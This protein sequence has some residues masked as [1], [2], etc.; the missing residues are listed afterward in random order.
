MILKLSPGTAGALLTLIAAT[1]SA[2]ADWS[3]VM[4]SHYDRKT[5]EPVSPPW[6]SGQP[7]PLWKISCAGGFG[8]FITGD[9]KAYTVIP[10]KAGG[11]TRETVV[12]LD[13]S[14][15][16]VIWEAPFGVA[17]YDGGGDRG[18]SGNDGGDGPRATP[19]YHD[20]RVFV[21]GGAFDLH[22]IE[23]ATGRIIWERDLIKDFGA[24]PIRWSNA[25]APLVAGDRVLV[26]GGS[27]GQCYLAFRATDGEVL[28]KTGSDRVS[29]ATPVL[30]TIHGQEQALFLVDRGLVAL[31]PANGR[32]LWH[33]PFAWRT[34]IGASPVV[35]NDIVHCTA[36]YGVGGAAV[37][38]THDDKTWAVKEL[39]RSRGNGD[40]A[41]HW[42]TPVAHEGYLYGC[43]GHGEYGTASFK[44][45]DIRTGKVA[46][47]ESGFGHGAV[48]LVGNR[49]LATTDFGR[50]TVI[51]PDP[52]AYRETARA[53]VIDGKC[54]A[55]PAFSDGRLL[56][57]STTQGVCIQW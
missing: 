1:P 10:Q 30:A 48:I 42:S 33:Y 43:Y 49:L 36:G 23:A 21:F 14:T 52:S 50:L 32:E 22:A 7:R 35:W 28:W 37:R 27:S 15:G 31:D 3:H 53:D 13:S 45:I 29:H 47:E 25:A 2:G 18:A 6:P 57:R 54:W 9:G 41:A 20:G 24:K 19:A 4:G 16:R 34:S 46:W 40:T 12:A 44:C 8:S 51:D 26:A 17:A 5:A 39:W 38:V 56:L 55:S 11:S